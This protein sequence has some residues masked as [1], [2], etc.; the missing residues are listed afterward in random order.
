MDVLER[1]GGI[2]TPSV[3]AMG[4]EIVRLQISGGL[5][6]TLQIMADRADGGAMTVD[7][8]AD[9]SHAVSAL[10]DVEDPIT[11]AYTLEVSSPGIDRPLTRLKDFERFKGFEARI[12]TDLPLDGRKRFRGTLYGVEGE[13]VLIALDAKTSQPAKRKP[14]AKVSAKAKPVEIDPGL[15]EVA[16]IPFTQVAKAR[17]ELTDELLA[18]AAADQGLAAGT[19]GGQ[20]DVDDTARPVKR[21]KV[22][23]PGSKN[24]K[25]PKKKGPGRFARKGSDITEEFDT[26]AGQSDA[27][28]G[29]G[30]V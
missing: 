26:T 8:C 13:N 5:R 18:A 11:S 2:I 6:P 3:E 17:L 4:Y 9:I 1:I 23:H 21:P 15:V 24:D 14:G 27:D 28:D 10:L 25:A 29:A 20:M 22:E 7:D 12:E 19:E 30:S 16:E